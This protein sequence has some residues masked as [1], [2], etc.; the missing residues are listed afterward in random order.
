MKRI[1]LLIAA[2]MFSAVLVAQNVTFLSLPQKNKDANSY[3]S[4]AGGM[5]G[6]IG[7]KLYFSQAKANNLGKVTEKSFLVYD[8]ATLKLLD[9]KVFNDDKKDKLYDENEYGIIG[10][11][12]F[13]ISYNAPETKGEAI[14]NYKIVKYNNET[15]KVDDEQPLF[16]FKRTKA[17][18]YDNPVRVSAASSPNGDYYVYSV[19]NIGTGDYS[20]A[21]VGKDLKVVWTADGNQKPVSA[22]WSYITTAVNNKGEAVI[23]LN[24]KD[25]SQK[26]FKSHCLG[27]DSK[28]NATGVTEV[29]VSGKQI[30]YSDIK[31]NDDGEFIIA[32]TTYQKY[33]SNDV[34]VYASG[35]F[36]TKL[37]PELKGIEKPVFEALKPNKKGK[38]EDP[39][40]VR[41]IFPNGDDVVVV[42]EIWSYSESN[43]KRTELCYSNIVVNFTAKGN[44]LF[45]M[46]KSISTVTGNCNAGAPLYVFKNDK[47]YI[48]HNDNPANLNVK[49]WE[50]IVL[51]VCQNTNIVLVTCDVAAGTYEKEEIAD[52]KS[53]DFFFI[54]YPTFLVDGSDVYFQ[55]LVGGPQGEGGIGKLSFK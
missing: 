7:D 42:L 33:D 3:S 37:K 32:G 44:N 1:N 16:T 51:R 52:R 34:L 20:I 6:K 19:M 36:H 29:I 50:D 15:F 39:V 5:I 4:L 48:L 28:G 54:S 22:Y 55:S 21:I 23:L 40:K 41:Q 27:F 12:L 35:C 9:T 38:Y 45:T 53:K 10:G 31:V 25:E 14:Y 11:Q 18:I 2:L 26:K 8:A 43:G 46:Y 47:L 24:D 17:K 13:S 30:H 49:N